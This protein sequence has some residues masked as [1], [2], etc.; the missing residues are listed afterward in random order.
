MA[1]VSPV[2]ESSP[3]RIPEPARPLVV[4]VSPEAETRR[5]LARAL[6]L[7]GCDVVA[8][9]TPEAIWHRVDG[10]PRLRAPVP[11]A[12]V[13][14]AQVADGSLSEALTELRASGEPV[15]LVVYDAAV[16]TPREIARHVIDELAG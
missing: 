4:V 13:V 8:R 16:A 2:W 15:P 12:I 10:R 1:Y 11:D 14:D 3:R 7:H 5:D 6:E 9:R